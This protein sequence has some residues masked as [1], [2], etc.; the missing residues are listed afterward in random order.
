MIIR[1]IARNLAEV[2]TLLLTFGTAVLLIALYGYSQADRADIQ[3]GVM[4]TIAAVIL[5]LVYR[6]VYNRNRRNESGKEKRL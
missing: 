5:A 2:M 1:F 3:A 6:T 4:L